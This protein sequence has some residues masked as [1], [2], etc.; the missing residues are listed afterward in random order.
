LGNTETKISLAASRIRGAKYDEAAKENLQRPELIAPILKTIVS[1]YK[2]YSCE[3]IVKFI[4]SDSISDDAVDDVSCVVGALPTELSSISEKVIRY[5]TR[6]KVINPKLSSKKITVYLHIDIEVQNDYRQSSIG[7]PVVKR[8]IYYGAREI[9]SQLGILT[10][11]TNYND[12]E[13]VYSIWICNENVP[14]I[15]QNTVTSY[16]ISKKDEIGTTKEPVSDYDLMEVIIVRRGDTDGDAD[17]FEYL[18]AFFKSDI[19]GICKF[20][21]IRKNEDVVKGVMKMTGLGETIHQKAYQ[22]GFQIGNQMGIQT[23]IL[24]T[25]VSLVKDGLIKVSD[26]AKKADMSEEAFSELLKESEQN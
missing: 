19:D 11:T 12:L 10:E 6:F 17:I 8:G 16:K 2:S 15:L 3:E 23:G 18:S 26:A 13:K 1:E 14:K 21:D 24:N 9:S 22:S 20:I 7:Y 5:D 4:V 25:L